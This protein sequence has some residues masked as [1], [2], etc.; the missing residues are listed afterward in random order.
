MNNFI[1]IYSLV[2]KDFSFDNNKYEINVN[3]NEEKSIFDVSIFNITHNI[4][5]FY[6]SIII[7]KENAIKLKNI[8]RL[9]FI[10]NYDIYLPGIQILDKKTIHKIKNHKFT[11]NTDILPYEVNET[12][13]IQKKAL[14]KMKN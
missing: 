11:L 7:D 8:I 4:N 3:Y 9:N 2:L 5:S 12:Y 1:T 6:K 13:N 10:D 14:K